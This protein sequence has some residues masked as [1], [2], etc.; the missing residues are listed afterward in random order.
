MQKKHIPGIAVA[1]VQGDQ[2]A[3]LG[4]YGEA[5]RDTPVT[6]QTSFMIGST[7]KSFT[8]LAVMQLVEAGKIE[9]D[10]PVQTYIPW[11][12][13][14]DEAASAQ[15]TVKHLLTQTSGFSNSAG[16][17]ELTASDLSEQAI[18]NSV[19][20]MA[21]VALVRPPGSAYEYSNINFTTLGLV[22][23]MVSGQSY[24]RYIQEHIFD[25][26][27]MKNSFTSQ[28]EAQLNGM[29]TGYNTFFGIPF[30]KDV[31][32][33][34]GNLPA[35]LLICSVED[36]AHYLIAQLNDGRYAET[37]VISPQGMAAMHAPLVNLGRPDDF[38]GMGWVISPINNVPTVWHGGE[39]VNYSTFMLMAPEQKLGI[40][41]LSNANGTFMMNVTEQIAAGVLAI[42][43]G[44]Q[45]KA[46]ETPAAFYLP[47]GSTFI[48]A[49]L[50]LLWIGWTLY[51]F[52]RRQKQT[53]PIVRDRRWWIWVIAVPL[54]VDLNLLIMSLVFIPAQWGMP[55]D[56]ML[57]MFP[58]C[59]VM[60]IG[61]AA[62]VAIWSV[63]RTVLTLRQ[64]GAA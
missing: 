63:L 14:A 24:E 30:A 42:L 12:R 38:Y 3:Y 16:L 57:A 47:F 44:E 51:R 25:P 2:V 10:A 7:T 56:A 37:G 35:G 27:E 45:P 11:F 39:N 40:A 8:A 17:Q 43:L 22:V 33:N 15:I 55:F 1:I 59:F 18:E 60:L 29:S 48:P 64:P 52:V 53:A 49:L 32:F 62:L 19:R 20:A 58:D 46:Y 31:P 9:L 21:D 4:S 61:G 36:L 50:S 26:L 34:R 23:Q 41:V 6:P 13:V 5:A 54:F 28:E